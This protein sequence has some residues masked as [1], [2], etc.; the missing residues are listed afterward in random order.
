MLEIQPYTPAVE[1]GFKK[2]TFKKLLKTQQPN[3]VY[4]GFLL[5]VICEIHQFHLH[6]SHGV[7]LLRSLAI[8]TVYGIFFMCFWVGLHTKNL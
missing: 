7:L 4:L 5:I 3:L 1:L 8:C 2:P 6:F